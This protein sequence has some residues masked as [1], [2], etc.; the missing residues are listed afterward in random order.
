MKLKIAILAAAAAT[1]ISGAAQAGP[2][3]YGIPAPAAVVVDSLVQPARIVC[4]AYG[5]CVRVQRPV[6]VP[7]V[8][9]YPRHRHY[10]GPYDRYD[11][12]GYGRGW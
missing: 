2:Y 10:R 7:P 4:D 8:V 12:Y 9:V 11:R 6:Y 5:R 1:L 3:G